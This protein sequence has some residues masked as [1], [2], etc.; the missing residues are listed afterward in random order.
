MLG[1]PKEIIDYLLEQNKDDIFEIKKRKSLRSLNANGYAWKLCS[2]IA[3]VLGVTKEEVYKKIIKEAGE[4][5]VVP[6]RREAVK[7]FISGWTRKGLGWLCD[8]QE[9]K[10]QGY[11]NVVIYYGS[12][13]Y[14]TKQMSNLINSL[15]QE[16]KNLGIVTLDD[17]EIERLLEEYEQGI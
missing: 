5:E 4:F 10:L 2:E 13:I 9:S 1:K 17:L 6:I 8:V 11:V 3:N 7:M 14:D 12:S 16:A 15:V